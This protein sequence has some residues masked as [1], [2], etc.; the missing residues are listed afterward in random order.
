MNF[1]RCLAVD[2]RTYA[3]YCRKGCLLRSEPPTRTVGGSICVSSAT[4]SKPLLRVGNRCSTPACP[5][6]SPPFVLISP[7]L[8][9]QKIAC[10]LLRAA[11][12][13]LKKLKNI[14]KDFIRGEKKD[15]HAPP[16]PPHLEARRAPAASR[17]RS[18]LS[19]APRRT[20]RADRGG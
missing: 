6:R 12:F 10:E 19:R 13:I 18:S 8:L 9:L 15:P 20:L 17:Q 16:P 14:R 2:I 5:V 4:R 1:P 7:R 3:N 11:R